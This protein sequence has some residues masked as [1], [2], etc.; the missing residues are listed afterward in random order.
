MYEKLRPW[1]EIE[2]CRCKTVTGLVLIDLLTD[3]PIH[4]ASCRGEIDPERLQLTENEVESIVRWHSVASALY[5]LWLDSG[6]YEHYAKEKLL[7]PRGQ[8]N[9]Q[10]QELAIAMSLRLPTRFWYFHDTED[11]DPIRCPVCGN[12][13]D[14][15]V[16]WGVGICRPCHVQM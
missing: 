12:Q 9:Q 15:A 8:I 13:L 6:E 1:T 4:C 2:S 11:G 10:A 7:D 3:N 5:R 16:E 14:A